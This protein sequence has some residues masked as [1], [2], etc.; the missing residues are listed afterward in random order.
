[1]LLAAREERHFRPTLEQRFRHR[2]ADAAGG[3]SN[4]RNA[5]LKG[6]VH[7]RSIGPVRWEARL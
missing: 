2:A 7:P 1:V 3:S 6:L 4:Q 5:I